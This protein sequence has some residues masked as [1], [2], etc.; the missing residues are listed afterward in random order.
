MWATVRGNSLHSE[1]ESLKKKVSKIPTEFGL[2]R[3]HLPLAFWNVTLDYTEQ[4]T[5]MVTCQGER[6]GW[7]GR[8]R[9]GEIVGK[10]EKK[11]LG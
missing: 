11:S 10:E 7:D 2:R 6:G 4:N 1:P 8:E 3:V 5:A 9:G